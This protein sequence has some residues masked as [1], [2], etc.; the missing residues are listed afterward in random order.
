MNRKIV[1][2]GLGPGDPDQLTLGAMRVFEKAG[3]VYLR[4]S[5]HPTVP[6][7]PP[8]TIL[9]NFDDIYDRANTFGEVYDTI[10]ARLIELA[11]QPG[12]GPVVYAVPGHPLVGESSVL[13]L[14]EATRKQGIETEI[15][16]G[17]SYFEPIFGTLGVDP[18]ADGLVVLDATELAEQ[19]ENSLPRPHGLELPVTRP[20]LI[21]QVYNQRLAGGV[22]LALME[23]YPDDHPVTLLRGAGI[24]GEEGRIDVPLYE[25]DRHPEW[26]DHLTSAYLPGLPLPDAYG[27]FA[28]AHYVVARLRAPGGCE[29]DRAQT[30]ASL[31]RHLLEEAYEV[32]HALDEEPD[33]LPE[34][35]GDLLLQILLHAQIAA[36]EGEW[37]IADV[38]REMSEK[39]VRRHPHIFGPDAENTEKPNWEEFKR[40]EKAA[41]GDHSSVLAGV[42]RDM[43]ALQQAQA[44]QRKAAGLGFKWRT[45]E[46]VM[47]KLVEEVQEVRETTN[48]DELV[49]EIGDVLAVLASA[50]QGLKVDAEEA[51]R[52][53]NLKFRRRFEQWE[54]IIKERGLDPHQM[55][56]AGLQA[57]W[58]E[59]RKRVD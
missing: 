4:T 18:L 12:E 2:V 42:P 26:T 45:F 23:N 36:E 16:H 34:E 35:L 29:W 44:L 15:V 10:V 47:D 17:L 3:T 58:T 46:E 55:D 9:E 11:G 39:L 13:R 51:L 40:T 56:L 28:N 30:H 52:L 5:K 19:P 53:A 43:P 7:L 38:F 31:K 50:A 24:P 59:A 32:I 20:L 25:L 57:I 41:K 48:H 54:A 22:K 1:I 8:N 33:A 37:S 14:L 6:F 21:G 27:T 49:E